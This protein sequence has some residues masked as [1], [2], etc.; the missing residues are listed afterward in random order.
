[1]GDE[2]RIAIEAIEQ[3]HATLTPEVQKILERAGSGEG[4]PLAEITSDVLEALESAG[5]LD[6]LVVRRL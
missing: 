1:M 2:L 3:E 5:V 6:G 4:F